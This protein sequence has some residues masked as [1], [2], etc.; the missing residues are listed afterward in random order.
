MANPGVSSSE[1]EMD[2][3]FFT[4]GGAG[5]W[6]CR[7]TTLPL[8]RGGGCQGELVFVERQTMLLEGCC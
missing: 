3:V 4:A 5:G 2:L 1:E 7:L 8:G 6:G